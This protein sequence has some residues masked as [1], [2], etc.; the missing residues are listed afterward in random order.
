[1]IQEKE[2]IVN[3]ETYRIQQLPA[4]KGVKVFFVLSKLLG[5]GLG[6][7]NKDNIMK[8]DLKSIADNIFGQIDEDKISDMV[9]GLINDSVV[10]PKNIS[11]DIHF[12]GKYESLAILVY[13]ILKLNYEDML[14]YL[15]KKVIKKEEETEK[16]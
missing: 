12:A 2:I 7:I 4:R 3:G 11:F 13:E 5:S 6:A 9:V 1:M 10:F 14:V 15:K 8:T 16:N